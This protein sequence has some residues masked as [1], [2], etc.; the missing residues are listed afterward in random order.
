MTYD[1]DGI[2]QELKNRLALLSNWSTTIFHGTYDRLLSVIAYIIE[3]LVYVTEFFYRESNWSLAQKRSSLMSKIDFL[4]YRPH[5]KIGAAGYLTVSYGSTFPA[6]PAYTGANVT[7]PQWTTFT[8]ST[9]LLNVYSTEEFIYRTGALGSESNDVTFPVSQGTPREFSY[10]ASGTANE[11]I[12]IYSDSIDDLQIFVYIVDA[13]NNIIHSVRRCEIDTDANG[14][15]YEKLYFIVD[16]DNYYCEIKNSPDFDYIKIIFS[17][18]LFTPKLNLEDRILIKYAETLGDTGNIEEADKITICKTPL[19]DTGGS[20]ATLYFTNDEGISDGSAIEDIEDIRNNAT[21]L[22]ASA[23]V[24]TSYSAWVT[25][26]EQHPYI[27]KVKIWSTDDVADDT[28]TTNQ[29]KVYVTAISNS[30]DALITAQQNEITLDYLKAIKSPTE[31]VSWQ[32]LKKVYASFKINAHVT[33]LP[34]LVIEQAIE[35]TLD[36]KYGILNTDFKTNIYESN[37]ISAIDNLDEVV[38]NTSEIYSMDKLT[39]S[40]FSNYEV[41]TSYTSADTSTATDQIYIVPNTLEVWASVYS[42]TIWTDPVKVGYDTSGT[43]VT[44]SPYTTSGSVVYIQNEVTCSCPQFSAISS[45]NLE[46]ALIYK[47]KDGNGNQT[48]DL[49]LPTFDCITD[50]DGKYNEYTLTYV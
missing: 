12:S 35:E 32:T 20:E 16:A 9:S 5:R 14:V 25:L 41:L 29:N 13:N 11:T 4:S 21:N 46:I 26:L 1:Y 19:F 30:G 48:T 15:L 37:Y 2:L 17:D 47:T 40:S 50:F 10:V 49:R 3:K 42:G 44:V 38:Y 7:I 22:F 23:K 31:I 6:T 27:Y 45:A 39:Q 36:A 28:L 8:D 33:N 34:Q 18:G 24:C 43:I